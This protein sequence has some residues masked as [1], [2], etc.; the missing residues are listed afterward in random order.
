[1]PWLI[2]IRNALARFRARKRLKQSAQTWTV[3]RYLILIYSIML[4]LGIHLAVVAAVFGG[5]LENPLLRA[6]LFVPLLVTLVYCGYDLY[7][8]WCWHLAVRLYFIDNFNGNCPDYAFGTSTASCWRWYIRQGSPL[9]LSNSRTTL[10]PTWEGCERLAAVRV[11]AHFPPHFP[12][13]ERFCAH[14]RKRR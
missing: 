2:R 11:A 5:E 3:Y 9:R 13:Y 6:L 8:A 1:M 7:R 12:N 10:K 4:S 14:L